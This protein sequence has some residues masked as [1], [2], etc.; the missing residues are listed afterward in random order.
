LYRLRRCLNGFDAANRA[1]AGYFFLF[2]QE[3]CNQKEGRPGAAD[4]PALL[5]PAGREPNSPNA[6][7]SDKASERSEQGFFITP[8]SDTGSRHPP[9]EAAMLGGGYGSRRQKQQQFP[10]S[11]I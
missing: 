4:T 11:G 1:A 2:G 7:V 8:G 10:K 3:K 5:A 6:Q 9:A